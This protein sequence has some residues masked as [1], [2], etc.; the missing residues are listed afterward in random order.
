MTPMSIDEKRAHLFQTGDVVRWY[1]CNGT[2]NVECAPYERFGHSHVIICGDRKG[3]HMRFPIIVAS[4]VE[5][6]GRAC[7]LESL[8]LSPPAIDWPYR[9]T[10]VAVHENEAREYSR[11]VADIRRRS[12]YHVVIA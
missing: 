3:E 8:P 4:V 11:L 12:C 5:I 10:T 7:P 2:F 9:S 6:N 1:G